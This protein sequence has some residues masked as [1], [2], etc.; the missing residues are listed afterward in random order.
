LY[1]QNNIIPKMQNLRGMKQL[2][3]LNLAL[4][5]ISKIE[6][7]EHCEFLNKLDL[8]LNF[9]DLDELETSI[10]HLVPL[11]NLRDFYMMGNPSQ[12]NWPGF[13]SYVIAKLPQLEQLDGKEITKSMKILA[14]QQLPDLD[15]QLK[16][17]A[18]RVMFEKK[19]K[20]DVNAHSNKSK[21]TK[22][23]SDE[24]G[25]D[26]ENK[27][28]EMTEN[29]PEARVEMYR[30]IAANKKE[31]QDRE[32]ANKPKKRD[33][34]KEQEEA[35]ARIREAEEASGEKEVRQKNEGGYAFSWDEDTPGV[36]TLD[37]SIPKHL[38]SSLI[39]VDVHPNYISIVI[40]SKLLRLRLPEEVKVNESKCQRSKMTGHLLVTMPRA[41][42]GKGK[43]ESI[44]IKPKSTAGAKQNVGR[45]NV[46]TGKDG[47]SIGLVERKTKK[48]SIAELMMEE[49]TTASDDTTEKT[50]QNDGDNGTLQEGPGGLD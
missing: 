22:D 25:N 17:L 14:Q 18:M 5:N 9:I 6:G 20:V 4:N 34:E 8:T 16:D 24:H 50:A 15:K 2:E 26:D 7:L 44:F 21:A 31:K 10:D 45:S 13:N 38:D 42:P 12:V 40:K 29:T 32:D 19:A 46:N 49:A 28:Q 47:N 43:V 41:N 3:Y 36:I 48:K 27:G 37:V 35:K 39:D 30:E 33:Y 23:C 1:L 11:T